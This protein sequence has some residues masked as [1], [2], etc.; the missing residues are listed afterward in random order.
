MKDNI[1]DYATSAFR[2]YAR[3]DGGS[4]GYI[5]RIKD[6]AIQRQFELEEKVDSGISKP[7]EDAAVYAEA[8]LKKAA[9]AIMDLEAVEI[10]I[11]NIDHLRLNNRNVMEALKTVY[12]AHPK[13]QLKKGEI[14]ERVHQAELSLHFCERTIYQWLE[15]ARYFFAEARGL[16]IEKVPKSMQ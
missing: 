13:R 12:M 15:L 7:T 5:N 9:A 1:R 10:A 14:S 8:A 6:E 3:T 16:R 4:E 2:F 11:S